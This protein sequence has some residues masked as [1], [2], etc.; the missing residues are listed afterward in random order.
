MTTL[1][2]D[3]RMEAEKAAQLPRKE[4]MD[5]AIE[6]E[7]LAYVLETAEDVISARDAHDAG[8]CT[9][10]ELYDAMAVMETAIAEA[11]GRDDA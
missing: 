1:R 6:R 7:K 11:R 3:A 4:K 2:S 5:A 10:E 8:E 9:D